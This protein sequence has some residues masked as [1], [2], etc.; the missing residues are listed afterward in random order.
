MQ[1]LPHLPSAAL[2]MADLPTPSPAPDPIR[3]W[4]DILESLGEFIGI[5]FGRENPATGEVEWQYLRHTEFDGIGGFA[6]LLR[7]SGASIPRL[8]EIT[9]P[10]PLSW[11]S[12]IRALPG[13][14]GPR[15]RLEWKDIPR[16]D[17][18]AVPGQEP[19]AVA[20]HVFSEEDTHRICRAARFK[21]ASVNS[22]LLKYLDRSV[23]PALQDPSSAMPW[24]VPVNLRG[25]VR[26]P[27]DTGNHSSY[28]GIRI[29][30]SEDATAVHRHIYDALAKGRHC[31]HWK[32]FS[33]GR[34]ITAGIKRRLIE[35]D[36]ATSQWS[37]GGFSNLGVWDPEKTIT[38]PACLGAWL[39]APPVLRFQMIGAGC[40]TFQ[41]RMSLTLQIHP[42]LTTSPEVASDWLKNW[43]REIKVDFPAEPL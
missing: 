43:I 16:G 27:A 1:F 38:A 31:A 21:P 20:W 41:G 13:L 7:R 37:V 11:A 10:A 42:E 33:A 12:F 23:R 18:P 29:Y 9:H 28:V 32:A 2:E 4:F 5:R 17:L 24:M 36:R 35:T 15:R 39:F 3:P 6:H 30:A 40:V 26:Q 19:T 8:P 22:L 34:F 25:K 14:L